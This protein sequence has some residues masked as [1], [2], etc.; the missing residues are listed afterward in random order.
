LAHDALPGV[1]AGDDR[2]R[3][4]RVLADARDRVVAATSS[5]DLLASRS[6]ALG[7]AQRCKAA[8]VA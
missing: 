2:R 5:I 4:H 6:D 1:R 3:R 8:T 7:R